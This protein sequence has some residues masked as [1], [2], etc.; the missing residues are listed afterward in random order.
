MA[1]P[2]R[3][4]NQNHILSIYKYVKDNFATPEG[5]AVNY[6]DETFDVSSHDL[7]V[8]I[9]F[10]SFGAGRK[11]ETMVQFDVYSRTRVP[12][13]G[14]DEFGETLS[15]TADTL[16]EA[17]RVDGIQIYDFAT[18]SSPVL[19]AGAKLMVQNSDG[20]FREPESD[21][22]P[23]IEDH[24]ARRSLTYRLRMV[25]DASQADSYYD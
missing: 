11:G 21:V 25:E 3:R 12:A 19:Q 2:A 14:G 4:L 15:Q 20:K 10:L 9:H 5:V 7:W 23:G 18:K 22:S 13:S 1:I 24:V 16:V 6:G 17:M 8:D